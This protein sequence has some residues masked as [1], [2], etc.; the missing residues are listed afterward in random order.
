[1]TAGRLVYAGN[2]V[3]LNKEKTQQALSDKS[4]TYGAAAAPSAPP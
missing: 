2:P 1:M 3:R 4:I